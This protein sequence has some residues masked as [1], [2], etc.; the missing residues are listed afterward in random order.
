MRYREAMPDDATS[1]KE[2]E[3]L[4]KLRSTNIAILP[5][6]TNASTDTWSALKPSD[7][8]DKKNTQ[9]ECIG[10]LI[11]KPAAVGDGRYYIALPSNAN[12]FSHTKMSASTID[13]DDSIIR[14]VTVSFDDQ[15]KQVITRTGTG[16]VAGFAIAGPYGAVGGAMITFIAELASNRTKSVDKYQDLL[17]SDLICNSDKLNLNDKE[18]PVKLALILPVVIGLN[19]A[20]IVDE[21]NKKSCW[22]ILPNHPSMVK[23]IVMKE[24]NKGWL[25]RVVL[26]DKPFGAQSRSEYFA[27]ADEPRHNFPVTPC[28]EAELQITW[29]QDADIK[30]KKVNKYIFPI[31]VANPDLI[32]VVP[33]PRA[34]SINLGTVC[35]ATVSYTTYSGPT[36]GDDVEAAITAIKNIKAAQKSN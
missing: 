34:G 13:G 1:L 29:W 4:F 32:Q 5:R 27:K 15:T 31:K 30:T 17:N 2:G 14:S 18:A 33:L 9:A 10:D 26:G 20:V 7:A 35:G 6:S 25:Y 36:I 19:E 12:P 22:H 8:C 21:N 11:V 23:N 16:A 24:Q 3:I 28:Q